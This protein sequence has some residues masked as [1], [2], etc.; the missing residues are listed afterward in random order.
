[1][2]SHVTCDAWENGE[3]VRVGRYNHLKPGYVMIGGLIQGLSAVP[4][5]KLS[6]LILQT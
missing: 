6:L 3:L 5:N 2:V 1:M 4:V